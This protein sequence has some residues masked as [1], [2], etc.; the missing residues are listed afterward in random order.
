[1]AKI[2]KTKD[3]QFVETMN[4]YEIKEF[5]VDSSGESVVRCVNSKGSTILLYYFLTDER[6]EQFIIGDYDDFLKSD[7]FFAAMAKLF[8]KEDDMGCI[9]S[10]CAWHD[11]QVYHVKG[12][13]EPLPPFTL[14]DVW[15][16]ELGEFRF[17][18]DLKE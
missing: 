2:I 17:Y 18:E 9:K 4:R 3:E 1:M 15:N 5:Y 8:A 16:L 10:L 13:E 12:S 7:R 11:Y 6:L 14:L